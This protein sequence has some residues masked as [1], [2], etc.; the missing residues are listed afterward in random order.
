MIIINVSLSKFVKKTK[1]KTKKNSI[2]FYSIKIEQ[3]QTASVDNV[4]A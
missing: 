4:V 3:F 1:T 2:I